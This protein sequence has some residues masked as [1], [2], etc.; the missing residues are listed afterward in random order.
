LSCERFRFHPALAITSVEVT[1]LD[2]CDPVLAM[3]VYLLVYASTSP[4]GQARYIQRLAHEDER[5]AVLACIAVE[6]LEGREAAWA[7]T[8]CVRLALAA[9]TNDR[10]PC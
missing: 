10:G 8:E 2:A 7:F 4:R 6:T 9:P 3:Q 5:A 1:P